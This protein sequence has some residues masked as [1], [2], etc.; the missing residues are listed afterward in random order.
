MLRFSTKSTGTD[1]R[2]W[3]STKTYNFV[4]LLQKF[5]KTSRDFREFMGNCNL[6][7]LYSSSLLIIPASV[8]NTPPE[9]ETNR[10]ARIP[11]AKPGSGELFL[12]VGCMGKARTKAVSL[13][14]TGMDRIRVH[15][16]VYTH[17]YII[18]IY[19]YMMHQICLAM[20]SLTLSLL[21]TTAAVVISIGVGVGVHIGVG[22]TPSTVHCL[23]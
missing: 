6:R 21:I 5:P 14:E 4:L 16:Y 8:K 11:S 10:K 19:M 17:G 12:L 9:K 3:L 23:V 15:T 7:I 1:G 13:T 22:L 20:L 18:C 2:K